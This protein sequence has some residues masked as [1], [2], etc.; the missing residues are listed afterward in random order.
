MEFKTKTSSDAHSTS[1]YSSSNFESWEGDDRERGDSFAAVGF[2]D[3]LFPEGL[4]RPLKLPPRL[5][6]D[7]DFTSSTP[8]S[9]VLS[10]I[11]HTRTV[12]EIPFARKSVWNDD[13]DPFMVALQ[14]V[15][16]EEKK[17][18]HSKN[19]RRI[20]SS[21]SSSSSSS[22]NN[23]Q[24]SCEGN[25]QM[26]QIQIRK[27]SYSGPLEF[28]GSSYARWVRSQIKEGGLGRKRTI[29]GS[30]GVLFGQRSRMMNSYNKPNSDKGKYVADKCGSVNC[31]SMVQ[32]LKATLLRYAS[33]GREDK[34]CKQ[35][36]TNLRRAEA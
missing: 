26:K 30:A 32:K 23:N 15:S 36:K 12:C 5:Q 20:I 13:F 9:P 19:L 17:G 2:A 22:C 10:P 16:Q 1:S 24:D 25:S 6:F 28:K 21:S 14:K 34:G 18:R 3:E 8:L 29:M 33:F 11:D 27:P 35:T 31:E 4:L 7:T